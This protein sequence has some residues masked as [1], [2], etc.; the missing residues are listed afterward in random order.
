M[1]YSK[2]VG[3]CYYESGV[4]DLRRCMEKIARKHALEILDDYSSEVNKNGHNNEKT[5]EGAPRAAGT[6]PR[7]T[8]S[9]DG[10][11][12]GP[13]LI[14]DN[15]NIAFPVKPT[16]NEVAVDEKESV[17]KLKDEDKVN[18]TS[19]QYNSDE[20]KQLI[21]LRDQRKLVFDS[22][23]DENDERLKKYLGL[24]VFDDM[25]ERKNKKLHVGN[26]Y[27]STIV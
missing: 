15:Q 12:K 7:R 11:E 18:I 26:T 14:L 10:T 2:E 23:L 27:R 19:E 21:E 13:E 9:G 3:W 4:R 24:P 17:N 6:T 20:A 5:K 1:I 22:S 25:Y 8:E 16:K